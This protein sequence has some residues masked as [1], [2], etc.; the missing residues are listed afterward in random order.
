[1]ELIT[2]SLLMLDKDE[3]VKDHVY[4]G[5]YLFPTVFGIEA[6][7]QNIALVT[8]KSLK[9][10][11]LIKD[12]KL[13]RP[14]VVHEGKGTRIRVQTLVLEKNDALAYDVVEVAIYAEQSGF[15]QPHFSA[16]FVLGEKIEAQQT[17]QQP[18]A[19]TTLQPKRDLYSNLLFQG[20]RFQQMQSIY[21]VTPEEVKFSTAL[22]DFSDHSDCPYLLGDPYYRDTLLQSGQLLVPDLSCL[23]VFI[24]DWYISNA[25]D[26]QE[27][28]RNVVARFDRVADKNMYSSVASYNTEGTCSELI[29][30]YQ[31]RI[32]KEVKGGP[33]PHDLIHPA[34]R[35]NALVAARYREAAELFALPGTGNSIGYDA[36]F[37]EANKELRHEAE[38]PV[39]K[40]AVADLDQEG[41][42]AISGLSWDDNGKPL[43]EADVPLSISLSHVEH[44]C[45]VVS[46][47][48]SVGFDFEN[49]DPAIDYER[50][51]GAKGGDAYTILQNRGEHKSVA[52]ARVWS[53]M[54][55]A[56]KLSGI[57]PSEIKVKEKRDQFVLFS[58]TVN[59]SSLDVLTFPLS[60]TLGTEK[61][62]AYAFI[63]S[64]TVAADHDVLRELAVPEL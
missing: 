58:C 9:E 16:R 10:D 1:V 43:V 33:K 34:K 57:V 45:V 4:N 50:L 59:E 11:L 39:I 53:T 49:I 32:L 2:E 44:V 6:M 61:M 56:I 62:F 35:D 31:L 46:A 37:Q 14:I 18:D 40:A 47:K 52:G 12:L 60:L 5:S 36:A 25:A 8:G 27:T 17:W 23:P 20:E 29:G 55:A 3:Y 51:L 64:Q 21:S 42:L 22:H 38:L 63:N 24:N 41:T 54:E 7:A 30:D 15:T 19:V 13:E 26:V 28:H 48:Q